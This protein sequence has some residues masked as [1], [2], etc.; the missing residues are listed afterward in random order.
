MCRS[1]QLCLATSDESR[2]DFEGEKEEGEV[3]RADEKAHP[4]GF[5]AAVVQGVLTLH[6]CASVGR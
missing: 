4:H 5:L 3:P 6:R 1:I 2:G